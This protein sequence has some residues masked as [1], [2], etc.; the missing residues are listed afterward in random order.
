MA[1][2]DYFRSVF[3]PLDALEESV[4]NPEYLVKELQKSGATLPEIYM[5][6]GTEDF[7]LQ[8]NRAFRDFLKQQNVAV[9]YEESP[10]IHDWKFWNE[11]LAKA[12]H[13][14]VEEQR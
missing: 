5:A 8:Q 4:N 11:Y 12:V 9:H 10:G 2:Y 6:C 14:A 7:L 3:G 1:D 13:W